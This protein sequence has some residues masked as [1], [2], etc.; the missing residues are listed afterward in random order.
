MIWPF[1]RTTDEHKTR[2]TRTMPR[3]HRLIPMPGHHLRSP[4]S[5]TSVPANSRIHNPQSICPILPAMPTS[6][7]ILRS[8]LTSATVTTSA[9]LLSG[10]SI[11]ITVK[12]IQL[13]SLF[14]PKAPHTSQRNKD[15]THAPTIITSTASH[16]T[17]SPHQPSPTRKLLISPPKG[18]ESQTQRVQM[19][20]PLAT[21]MPP[22]L[23]TITRRLVGWPL[24]LT[25]LPP[26]LQSLDQI[27]PS[28]PKRLAYS[29]LS[30]AS[31]VFRSLLDM[32]LRTSL[33]P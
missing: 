14:I 11:L 24:M 2:T 23:T 29:Q 6:L 27:H 4:I 13:R 33:I 9:R 32:F 18:L 21:S 28:P 31:L 20:E 17:T 3:T 26:D 30:R 7:T 25:L 16:L 15:S 5:P 19:P 10:R 8:I 1:A 22:S 12:P